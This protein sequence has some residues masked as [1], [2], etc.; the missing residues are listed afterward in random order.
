MWIDQI[1]F[2]E[3]KLV[4][5]SRVLDL[6]EKKGILHPNVRPLQININFIWAIGHHQNDN[7]PRF[8]ISLINSLILAIT[9]EEVPSLS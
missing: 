8:D 1:F 5:A 2:F 4:T 3:S 7:R 9:R 6:V